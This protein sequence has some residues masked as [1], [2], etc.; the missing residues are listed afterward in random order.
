MKRNYKI[1]FMFKTMANLRPQDV[2]ELQLSLTYGQYI[3]EAFVELY[4]RYGD[5]VDSILS[6]EEL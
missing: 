6:I 3:K 4:N 5:D 2:Q 1:T